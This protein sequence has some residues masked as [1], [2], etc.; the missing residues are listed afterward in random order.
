MRN[1]LAAL[2][3]T[4]ERAAAEL[5]E[6]LTCEQVLA[7]Q[8][9]ILNTPEAVVDWMNRNSSEIDWLACA[10]ASKRRARASLREEP[11][12]SR[13]FYWAAARLERGARVARG[14]VSVPLP[15]MASFDRSLVGAALALYDAVLELEEPL[16]RTCWNEFGE[17]QP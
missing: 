16:E 9:W 7:V 17:W 15:E 6:E 1:P 12:R 5:A 3:V 8:E 11:D 13:L 2:A 4:A 14:L 10:T